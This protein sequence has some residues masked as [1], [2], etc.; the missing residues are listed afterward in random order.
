MTSEHELGKKIVKPPHASKNKQKIP[1]VEHYDGIDRER[2]KLAKNLTKLLIFV[3][4]FN[5]ITTFF[6][7]ICMGFKWIVLSDITF[8]SFAVSSIGV[9]GISSL[10]VRVLPDAVSKN[11]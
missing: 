11:H 4:L 5:T 2:V 9:V 3:I 10:I 1:L 7:T 6:V 8:V